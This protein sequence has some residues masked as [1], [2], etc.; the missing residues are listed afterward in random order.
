MSQKIIPILLE[1]VR[2]DPTN[3][4]PHFALANEYQKLN[5][6]ESA[7]K[8]YQH[9]VKQFPDYGGTYYHYALLLIDENESN[10]ARKIIRKGLEV[11]ERSGET[12]LR[13]EL[14]A[15]LDQYFDD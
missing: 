10:E 3:P 2:E 8:H 4:F 5:D 11:L 15:L 14:A 7:R 12:N 6:I 9:L 1:T 13:N